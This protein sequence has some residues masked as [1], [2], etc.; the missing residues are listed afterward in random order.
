MKTPVQTLYNQYVE[1]FPQ[2]KEA[3]RAFRKQ[4]AAKG[5]EGI[6]DRKTFDT[7]H[8][9]AG[10]IVVSLPSKKVLLIDHAVLRKQLQPGGHVEPEDESILDA[11]YREC[12][13]EAG[14]SPEALH[15][16][17]LS[18]QNTELPFAIS[19]QDIPANSAKAE[20]RHQHYDFWYLF[21]V[22]DGTSTHS[23]DDG[24]SNPQWTP[25]GT[26][27]ENTEFSRQAEKINKLLAA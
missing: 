11:A 2:E 25:F 17:P 22:P 14:I 10:S 4:L 24:A 18:D 7:G 12:E 13:E 6:T 21:T 26:F 20:P 3:L 5:E 9:T 23:D 19:V 16:I 1:V 15:Y 27:A 8:V